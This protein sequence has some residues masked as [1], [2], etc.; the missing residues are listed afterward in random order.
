MPFDQEAYEIGLDAISAHGAPRWSWF[1]VSQSAPHKALSRLERRPYLL[2]LPARRSHAAQ[3]E[4]ELV[5]RAVGGTFQPDEVSRRAYTLCHLIGSRA[6][7]E[8]LAANELQGRRCQVLTLS[9]EDRRAAPAARFELARGLL[10]RH[11]QA[12]MFNRWPV[13]VTAHQ[14]FLGRFYRDLAGVSGPAEALFVARRGLR[15]QQGG[16]FR[17]PH[18]WA[19]WVL[20][21]AGEAAIE[22]P[23]RPLPLALAAPLALA[24]GAL[25]AAILLRR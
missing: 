20:L 5:L 21:G 6:Q 7:I 17:H 16:R 22:L 25:L 4:A 24:L 18:F 1:T 14:D 15:N 19:S 23:R 12:V 9:I 3:R 8:S 2:I 11:A 13:V 10:R